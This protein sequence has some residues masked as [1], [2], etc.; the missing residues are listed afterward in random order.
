MSFLI[1]VHV[2]EGMV[3][4]SDRRSTYTNTIVN[5]NET[6]VR[7]GVHS[8]D[9]TCKTF[10]CPNGAG[11]STCGD[12][13]LLE[14]PLTGFIQEMIRTTILP[15]T[16]V[17]EIPQLV[18][19]YFN[20][21]EKTPDTNFI[22]AGY[23]KDK[24]SQLL[25]QVNVREKTAKLQNTSAQ[26]ALWDGEISTLTRLVQDVGLRLDDGSYAPLPSE[27]ILWNYFTLQDA[28]DFARYAVETT[29]QTMRFKNVV[30]TVGGSVDIL[31]I[32]PDDTRWLQR[33]EI[34]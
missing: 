21:L 13:S 28:V 29:I 23:S 30:K 16:P 10:A 26:G 32:T 20:G 17:E 9:S 5:G 33:R 18:I 1:A 19:D 11:I 15:E 34:S 7:M 22:V 31:L 8:T 3:L 25:Y 2:N 6:I 4:A 27:D 12:A 24:T 14:K